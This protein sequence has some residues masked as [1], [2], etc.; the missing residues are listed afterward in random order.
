MGLTSP[1]PRAEVKVHLSPAPTFPSGLG[2]TGHSRGVRSGSWAPRRR[3]GHRLQEA[4]T[5]G[6]DDRATFGLAVGAVLVVL[7]PQ[8]LGQDELVLLVQL[9]SLLPAGTRRHLSSGAEDPGQLR[10]RRV[11]TG[12]GLD[13]RTWSRR[14]RGQTQV[15]EATA[16]AAGTGGA[17]AEVV[18]APTCPASSPGR[19]RTHREVGDTGGGGRAAAGLPG[20]AAG[21]NPDAR[22][23]AH[24]LSFP[25]SQPARCF[26]SK[27]LAQGG[28][29]KV[30]A[31][32]AVG[33]PTF[34]VG[35]SLKALNKTG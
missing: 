33:F 21:R 31:L 30:L 9:L 12:A 26:C 22:R 3:E 20:G 19:P 24:A 7:L 32:P 13:K 5:R 25:G 4:R 6:G 18:A 34:E 2:P 23:A 1:P 35:L 29:R 16:A 14:D 28:S 15:Q 11:R 8:Q 10:R 17:A 27:A